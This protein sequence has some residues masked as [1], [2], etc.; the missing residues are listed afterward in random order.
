MADGVTKLSKQQGNDNPGESEAI[1]T[2]SE[3]G[4]LRT[5]I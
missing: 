4:G 3:M 1:V 5:S 2:L